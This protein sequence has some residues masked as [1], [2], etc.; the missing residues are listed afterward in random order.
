[1]RDRRA[2]ATATEGWDAAEFTGAVHAAVL[3]P[4]GAPDVV[5]VHGLGCSHRYFLPL[6]RRLAPDARV[7][8]VD[9]PGFGRTPGPPRAADVRGLSLAL[10]DWL[11]ATGRG[12]APLVAHSAGCQV[13]ADLAAHSPDLAAPAVLLSPTM[14]RH[15]RSTSRQ[16]A[17]LAADAPRERPALVPLLTRDYLTAGV[18]RIAATLDHLLDDPVEDKVGHLHAPTAV[19]RGRHDPVVSRRWAR[20]VA[21]LLP[22]GRLV[23]VPGAAHAVHHSAPDAVAAI[24]RSALR[25][26]QP[27]SRRAPGR[28]RPAGS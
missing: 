3:G 16:L 21:A 14:D 12:G 23:E 15:A 26:A 8:A 6:A 10:A 27:R 24:T 9:L 11:R 2:P 17:R 5:L 13:V 28:A 20:E 25:A 19:V 7:A 22:D 4:A 18:R 1:M